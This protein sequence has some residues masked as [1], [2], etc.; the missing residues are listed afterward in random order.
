[1]LVAAVHLQTNARRHGRK[2]AH[3][4]IR[5]FAAESTAVSSGW[6]RAARAYPLWFAVLLVGIVVFWGS[7]GGYASTSYS[8][9]HGLCAQTPSHTFTIGGQPLPFDARMTGIYAGV[10]ATLFTLIAR[11]QVFFYGNP[12]RTVV[13][14]LGIGVAAMAADGVN[15]LL[16]DL[17]IW[18]PWATTNLTRLLTG[19]AT[20][21]ALCTA[22]CWLLASSAW[23]MSVPDVAVKS[24]RDLVPMVAGLAMWGGLIAW[25]PSGLHV[26]LT[27]ALV[28][29]AWI[30]VTLL[31]LV[32][33]ILVLRLDDTATRLRDLHVPG[34]TAAILATLVMMSL[35]AGRFW[36]ENHFGISNAML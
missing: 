25:A 15:S 28:L 19:Y 11:R 6:M 34:A 14:V 18:H 22:L 20:G 23:R 32:M 36:I 10:L 17:G 26:V 35:A 31:V 21:I 29:S 7:P 1:M 30:T 9:L 27:V 4:T 8:I 12:P 33:V 5:E 24:V 13:L 16:T 2:G 3:V